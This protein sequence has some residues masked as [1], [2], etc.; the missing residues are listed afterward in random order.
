MTDFYSTA[1][2]RPTLGFALEGLSGREEFLFKSVVRLLDHRTVQRWVYQPVAPDLRVI[3]DGADHP[4]RSDTP[5]QLTLSAAPQH[6]PH[7]LA[8]PLRADA[9]EAELNLLGAEHIEARRDLD[10]SMRLLRWPSPNMV[11]SA[12]RLKLAAL[13]VGGPFTLGRLQQRSGVPADVCAGFVTALRQAGMLVACATTTPTAPAA[14]APAPALA[15]TRPTPHGA[16]APSRAGLLTRIRHRL[17]L[18]PIG[19]S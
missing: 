5:L 7:C 8:F 6:P 4:A 17:G 12:Q 14:P 18:L 11:D 3:A 16:E 9:L 13:M 1:T 19:L 15:A 2:A 10:P